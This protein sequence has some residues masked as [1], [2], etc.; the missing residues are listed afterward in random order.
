MLV[1]IN[2]KRIKLPP[3][4]KVGPNI[5]ISPYA[6]IIKQIISIKDGFVINIQVVC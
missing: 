5:Y 3:K 1:N 6:Y 2:I 4:T